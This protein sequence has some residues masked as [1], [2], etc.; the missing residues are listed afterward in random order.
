[1]VLPDEI[2][3]VASSF[4]EA[5]EM[6]GDLFNRGFPEMEGEVVRICAAGKRALPTDGH[7]RRSV[8]RDVRRV[9][10]PAEGDRREMAH[11]LSL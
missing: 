10:P 8:R 11:Q 5:G 6:T 2:M 1:M 4:G 3:S 7:V 9:A